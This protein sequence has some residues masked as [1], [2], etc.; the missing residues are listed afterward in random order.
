[1]FMPLTRLSIHAAYAAYA[2][3]TETE[4]TDD[5]TISSHVVSA[6]VLLRLKKGK[7]YLRLGLVTRQ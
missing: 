7:T 1:M 4:P 5:E 6:P 2:A 3:Y